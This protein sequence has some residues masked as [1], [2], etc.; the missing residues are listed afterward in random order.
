MQVDPDLAKL[1]R[2]IKQAFSLDISDLHAIKIDRERN[3]VYGGR[4]KGGGVIV[5]ITSGRNT[6]PVECWAYQEYE[7]LGVPVPRIIAYREDP[8]AIGY[9]TMILS[10]LSGQPLALFDT[11]TGTNEKVYYEFGRVVRAMHE[12]KVQGFGSLLVDEDGVT[13]YDTS[14]QKALARLPFSI[15]VHHLCQHRLIDEAEEEMLIANLNSLDDVRLDQA[16]FIHHD[17]NKHNVLVED[18]RIAGVL[19]PANGYAGDP[20]LDI[21]I[22]YFWQ[23]R[24]QRQAFASGYGGPAMDPWVA[25]YHVWA[26]AMKLMRRHQS[27]RAALAEQA[28]RMLTEALHDPWPN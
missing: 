22:A 6:F 16:V 7:R 28:R 12:L 10:Q 17:L 24:W 1:Q 2:D 8:R 11:Q 27:G 21:A 23:A 19:D 4:M 3:Q 18:G 13:G 20:R 25:R 9:P 5:R 15:T 14:W 26:S